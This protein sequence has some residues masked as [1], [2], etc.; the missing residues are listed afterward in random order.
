VP[1]EFDASLKIFDV[2]PDH[3]Y[4]AEVVLTV[5]NE[6]Q[7][8]HRLYNLWCEVRQTQALKESAKVD[9]YLPITNLVP[10]KI[11]YFFIQAGVSQAF[12]KT[13]TVPRSEKLVRVIAM[14]T[15]GRKRL[16]LEHLDHL[17]FEALDNIGDTPHSVS[18]LFEVKPSNLT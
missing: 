9:A 8:E 11:E 7:R 3:D 10:K 12:P 15:Y 17:T 6:G 2:G 1:I 4:I 13:F 5:N 14:F 16:A 18:K